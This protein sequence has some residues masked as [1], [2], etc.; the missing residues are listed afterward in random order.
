MNPK[1]ISQSLAI[2]FLSFVFGAANKYANPNSPKWI[3]YYPV[4]SITDTA[5][6]PEAAEEGDPPYIS[7]GEALDFFNREGVLFVDAR[8]PWDYEQGH[9]TGAVNIPFESEDESVLENFLSN[10]SK[11]Q[12][13]VVYC[14]G[15]E[16]D[17][18]LYLGRTLAYEGFGE[19][20][21]FFGGWNDWILKELPAQLSAGGGDSAAGDSEAGQ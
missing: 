13:M 17:L 7:V 5:K 9:I 15:A 14:N 3:G 2:V 4:S 10:T 16:C 6:I 11:D 19:V 8:D 20:H 21:I 12:I 1:I 18:S